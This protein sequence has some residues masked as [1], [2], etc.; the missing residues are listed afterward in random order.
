MVYNTLIL[1]L[2]LSSLDVI[3]V[4]QVLTFSVATKLILGVFDQRT[5]KTFIH[6]LRFTVQALF[7]EVLGLTV[8][9]K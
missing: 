4:S 5:V 2:L 6:T 8:I 1:L 7:L 3:I 9:Y